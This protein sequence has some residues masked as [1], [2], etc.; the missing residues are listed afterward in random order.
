MVIAAFVMSVVL[1]GAAALM[2]G[3]SDE[4]DGA[5]GGPRPAATAV[6][7]TA[8]AEARQVARLIVRDI[9]ERITP[10][11]G[12]AHERLVAKGAREGKAFRRWVEFLRQLRARYGVTRVYTMV[13]L[14]RETVGVVVEVGEDGDESDR[15]MAAYEMESAMKRAFTGRVAV[16]R[17]EPW[18]DPRIRGGAPHLRALA[19]VFDS[20]G[21][22]VA[23]IG[24][25]LEV[26]D[27]RV[28]R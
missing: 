23:V 28:A 21:E 19:P 2:A 20:A 9:A 12:D 10:E 6:A 5:G 24:L 13:Q 16:E 22:V 3:G 14:D 25:D 17:G 1:V 26:G 15:W 18:F 27:R 8:E 11:M 7:D 4:R